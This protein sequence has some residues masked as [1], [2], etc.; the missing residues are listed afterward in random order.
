MLN[1]KHKIKSHVL[2]EKNPLGLSQGGASRSENLLVPP[3]PAWM[4][5]RQGEESALSTGSGTW[6]REQLAWPCV[7]IS[8][9]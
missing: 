6:G 1:L 3:A 8:S 4:G 5:G 7:L 2:H 9:A